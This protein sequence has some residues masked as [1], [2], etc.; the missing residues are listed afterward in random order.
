[1][2]IDAAKTF[3]N[4]WYERGNEISYYQDFWR[5]LLHFVFGIEKTTGFIEFQK[6]VPQ[7]RIDAYIPSTKV[8]IEHK[9]SDIILD[10]EIYAQ[11]LRYAKALPAAE[12]PRWIITCNF[13]EFRIYKP[14]RDEP[15]IIKLRDL[16]YQFPRLKFLIDPNAD[17]S[18][19]EEKVSKEALEIISKI[20]DAFAK[21]YERNKISGYEDALNKICTRLVF[22]LYAGDAN[23]FDANQFFQY[24]QKFSDSERNIA[25]Q[26]LFDALNTPENLRG[27]LDDDLKNFPYVNGGLFDEKISLPAFNKNVGNPTA[28]IGAF[29]ARKKFSWHEISPPIFG[30]MFESTFS[31]ENKQRASGMFYTS[32]ENI[33]KVI[34][35]LFMDDLREEFEL[36]KRRQI[37]NR[38]AALLELQDKLSKLNFLDPACGSGNFL[39]ETYLSLRRLENEILEELRGLRV[40]LPDNPIKVSIGQFY[41]IEIN[42]FAVAVAQTALWIAENQMLQETEGAIGKN[43][44]ALPL[45]NY[46]TI[47]KANALK[48]DWRSIFKIKRLGDYEIKS[49]QTLNL[50]ISPTPNLF[51]IGNPPFVGARMKSAAQAA[52]IQNIFGGWQNIGNLD[53]VACWYKKAADFMANEKIRA[54]LVSTNSIC[55]GDSVGTLWKNLFASGIHIDF[56]HRTFKWLS[57]SDNMAHVHC[58]VVGFSSAPNDKPKKIYDGEKVTSAQN[59]N[60]YLVDGEDIFVES[61]PNHLQSFVPAIGIG[62]K[63]IDNGNYLFTPDEMEDFIKHEPE[64]AKY[65]KAWYGAEEFIKGKRRFCLLLKDLPLEE[66]K[67]MPLCWER[68]ENVRNYRLKSKSPGTRKIADKPTRFHVEN[69]PQGNY[70]L[71]PRHSAG[72]RSYIP[73]GF[74]S[75]ETIC[76]DSNLM[77]PNATLYGFGILTSSIHMAW[78]K[79]V[80]SY[81][82][83]SYRYSAQIVY[84]NFVWCEPSEEQKELIEE[85]AQRILDVRKKYRDWTF[86]KLYNEDTMPA[87][88]RL[89]HKSNDYAVAMAYGFEK[90]LDDEPRI[91]AELMK[92]YKSLTS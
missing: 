3:A 31:R 45:K 19:P 34:D 10:K 64:S 44:Q 91:V 17:D 76:G 15:T 14:D 2:N 4:E 75:S 6:P 41:G 59:I 32:V 53:Y 28:S 23:L 77:I 33:H 7:G 22:C 73:I 47:I 25:L 78:L 50:L 83:T 20:Y 8:L 42:G 69:F 74:L 51:I 40:D 87:P 58:V 92:L 85:S 70:I 68:V 54:A 24:L 67:K 11:A 57:D 27:T 26:N 63:P 89:A 1:M 65:F 66:I 84:N 88:L 60:A 9:S 46:A 16:R 36:A 55:Q 21:N 37:K 72:T 56:C 48:I 82:G 52:D 80:G 86:A 81:L 71:V 38:A 62:N 39:T 49:E 13:S 61:R 30:A 5:D 18:P 43:L 29:N 79:I 35:P 90:F 12:K